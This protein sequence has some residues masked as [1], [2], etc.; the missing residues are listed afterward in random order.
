M[1]RASRMTSERARKIGELYKGLAEQFLEAGMTMD[2]KTA[3]S[4]SDWW[5]VHAQTLRCPLFVVAD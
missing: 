4:V 5:L 1:S 3:K 2:A